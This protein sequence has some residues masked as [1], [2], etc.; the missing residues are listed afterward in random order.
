MA[1]GTSVYEQMLEA[2]IKQQ[3]QRIADLETQQ[4]KYIILFMNQSERLIEM[5]KIVERLQSQAKE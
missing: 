2:T 1:E 4:A 5:S 3:M